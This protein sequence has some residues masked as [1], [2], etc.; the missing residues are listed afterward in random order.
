MGPRQ[1]LLGTAGRATEGGWYGG[2]AAF[3]LILGAV[4]ETVE[5]KPAQSYD[6]AIARARAFM[7][8]DDA[9]ILPE[10]RTSLLET[11]KTTPLSVVLF[12]GITNNPAQYAQ[13]APLLHARGVNVFVPRM[14]EHGDRDRLTD[15]IAN[16]TAESLLASATEA[17]DIASGLG[18]RVGVLGISMGGTL[19]AYFAQNRAI[20]VAVPVAPDFALLQLPYAVSRTFARIF[21]M[22]PNFFFWWDPR[23]RARQRPLTAYPRCSTRALVQ[24]LRIGDAVFAQAERQRPLADRIV[25]VVNRCDPAVNN[26]VTKQIS[27][28]W[29][30]WNRKG[31][32]YVEMRRLPE[33]HDIIDPQNPLART[34]LVYPR[35][36]EALGV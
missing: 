3:W 5:S 36:L 17:V 12:H 13:F 23:T 22:L 25:T 8:L 6:E 9:S 27:T 1:L 30:G 35:L 26:E 18:Q 32:D 28:E 16:L 4:I 10:A 7:A 24:T 19:A 31:V 21:L 14:P 29:S 11:G 15:R 34:Q 2:G 20:G 33:N